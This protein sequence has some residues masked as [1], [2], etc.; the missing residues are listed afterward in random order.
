M[1]TKGNKKAKVK[2]N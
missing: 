2:E 1:R